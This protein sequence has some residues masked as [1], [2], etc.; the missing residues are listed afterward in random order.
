MPLPA[1][2][3]WTMVG[4]PGHSLRVLPFTVVS[5]QW[6]TQPQRPGPDPHVPGYYSPSNSSRVYAVHSQ[7][8]GRVRIP[9]RNRISYISGGAVDCN[10][11]GQHFVLQPDSSL[12]FL[13][14]KVPWLVLDV[15]YADTT[16]H[17]DT[18]VRP[19][20][21]GTQGLV[22]YG[23]VVNLYNHESYTR[24][25][26]NRRQQTRRKLLVQDEL[27]RLLQ[28]RKQAA[29]GGSTVEATTRSLQVQ[30][31]EEI[32]QRLRHQPDLL[33][34]PHDP[35][36]IAL[37]SYRGKIV[38]ATVSVYASRI[39]HSSVGE[40]KRLV[41]EVD[42]EPIW[43]VRSRSGFAI[44]WAQLEYLGLPRQQD[45]QCWVPFGPLWELIAGLD[46]GEAPR[47]EQDQSGLVSHCGLSSDTFCD[48]LLQK[49]VVDCV[50]YRVS[51]AHAVGL[52]GLP[53]S[54]QGR[55]VKRSS[56]RL[57]QDCNTWSISSED[58]T[59]Q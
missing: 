50:V 5:A 47:G 32:R 1:S 53:S 52:R 27:R 23:I 2:S 8:S 40:H 37:L 29:T 56:P 46:D 13:Q 12:L 15:A 43:A 58:W 48:A 20:L 26:I 6:G 28:A 17:S 3:D 54:S 51:T 10:Y 14:H 57:F 4:G 22:S 41:T 25:I 24:Q 19:Y 42:A 35:D 44:E 33:R 16:V 45:D 18:K 11:A 31:E 36:D 38:F 21:F 9:P 49:L 7:R 55:A 34:C 30:A 59:N 39:I